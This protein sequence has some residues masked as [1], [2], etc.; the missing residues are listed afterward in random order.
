MGEKDKELNPI[1]AGIYT[2]WSV[3]STIQYYQK[4]KHAKGKKEIM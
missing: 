4:R 1:P 2:V 3:G